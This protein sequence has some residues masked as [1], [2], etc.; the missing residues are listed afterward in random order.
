MKLRIIKPIINEKDFYRLAFNIACNILVE[1]G[2]YKSTLS[3]ENSIKLKILNRYDRQK[4]N[5]T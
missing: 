2:Y 1:N 4:T 5:N 3:A